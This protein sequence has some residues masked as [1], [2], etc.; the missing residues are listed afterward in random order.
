M[1]GE[2]KPIDKRVRK[3]QRP[4]KTVE[5]LLLV[6]RQNGHKKIELIRMGGNV[7]K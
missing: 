2:L 1:R 7:M 3:R 5:G 6:Q 4:I